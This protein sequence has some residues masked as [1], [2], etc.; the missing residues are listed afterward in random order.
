MKR[1]LLFLLLL[2]LFSFAQ[3]FDHQLDSLHDLRKKG[4]GQDPQVEHALYRLHAVTDLDSAYYYASSGL[5]LAVSDSSR[6]PFLLGL[7][8]VMREKAEFDKAKQYYKEGLQLALDLTK[9]EQAAG[10][11]NHLGFLFYNIAQYDSALNCFLH[12]ARADKSN[13]NQARVYHGLGLVHLGIQEHATAK[14]YFYKSE[15]F[16]SEKRYLNGILAICYKGLGQ[17]D[18]ALYHGRRFVKFITNTKKVY[19]FKVRHSQVALTNMADIHQKISNYDSALYY[20]DLVEQQGFYNPQFKAELYLVLARVW[21]DL[22]NIDK[23]YSYVKEAYDISLARGYRDIKVSAYYIISQILEVRGDYAGALKK[24]QEYEQLSDSLTRGLTQNFSKFNLDYQDALN[25]ELVSSQ[26]SIIQLKNSTIQL[27]RG[28]SRFLT[29]ASISISVVLILL[30]ILLLVYVRFA[31]RQ[32]RSNK[33]L[34]ST[35]EELRGTQ[36]KLI[37]QEK[38]AALGQ[39]VAGIGHELNTP[40]GAMRGLVHPIPDYLSGIRTNLLELNSN[41]RPFNDLTR[42]S[43]FT[44]TSTRER[45]KLKKILK[46]E[47]EAHQLYESHLAE[48]L[49]DMGIYELNDD[50]IFALKSNEKEQFI[51]LL[52]SMILLQK[53]TDQVESLVTRISKVV[54]SL[55]TYSQPQMTEET[56]DMDLRE[57]LDSTLLLLQ[58]EFKRGVKIHKIYPEHVPLIAANA[59]ALSQVWTNLIL[60]SLHAVN[61]SGTIEIGICDEADNLKVWVKDNGIGIK[62]ENKKRIFEAFYTTKERGYGTGL[63]LNISKK[64]IE[65]HGGNIT[66]SSHEGETIFEVSLPKK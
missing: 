45:R 21:L 19:N 36:D 4:N 59:N 52:H 49:L 12:S 47:L 39:L 11:Y 54:R 44:F 58:G 23:A 8:Y 53:N 16:S 22:D 63:G 13:A 25:R 24:Y 48:M 18:S 29:V 57:S 27:Q 26:D 61:Y 40:L 10:V 14:R 51:G 5:S 33:T 35:L 7:G 30:L 62:Q 15:K 9:K 2:P 60:N 42:Q 17:Y 55:Q 50:L 37:L 56:M 34:T 66:F 64:I 43:K 28:K 20:A 6:I 3:D 65:N 38:M 46:A 31:A 1:C 32:K 41:L